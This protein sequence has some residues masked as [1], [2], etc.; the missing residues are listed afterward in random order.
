ML[1]GG[2]TGSHVNIELAC[3]I[4]TDETGKGVMQSCSYLV[5]I[6]FF[7]SEYFMNY[8]VFLFS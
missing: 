7:Y 2:S 4:F 3:H 8:D 1:A 5:H 6:N